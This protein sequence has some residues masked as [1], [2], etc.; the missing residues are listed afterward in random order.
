MM[1]VVVGITLISLITILI[2]RGGWSESAGTHA[3]IGIITIILAILNPISAL[4]RPDK[5]SG[6]T[7]TSFFKVYYQD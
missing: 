4:L 3:I 2:T 7:F 6:K 1:V 5:T